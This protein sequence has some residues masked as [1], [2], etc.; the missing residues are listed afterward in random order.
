MSVKENKIFVYGYCYKGGYFL[1]FKYKINHMTRSLLFL[2]YWKTK[3]SR[4][5]IFSSKIYKCKIIRIRL[6]LWVQHKK[7]WFSNESS[8]L[9]FFKNQFKWY[10]KFLKWFF[11]KYFKTLPCTLKH[12]YLFK[13]HFKM[14]LN[15]ILV[16]TKLLIFSRRCN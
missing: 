4:V 2:I 7:K 10:S 1:P 9:L 3:H 11:F 6:I 14:V 16:N 12:F 13:N 15:Y 8:T 5:I